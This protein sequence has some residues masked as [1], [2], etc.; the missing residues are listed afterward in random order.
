MT[1][2]AVG[3]ACV[4]GQCRKEELKVGICSIEPTAER[5]DYAHNRIGQKRPARL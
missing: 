1:H 3:K 4:L 5:I 2:H